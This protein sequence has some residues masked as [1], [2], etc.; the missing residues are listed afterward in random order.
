MSLRILE[1]AVMKLTHT[2]IFPIYMLL[3]LMSSL[4]TFPTASLADPP[5]PKPASPADN[6]M[7]IHLG[8]IK[9]KGER[10]VIKTLQIIK[11]ALKQPL[12]SD[13]KLANAV[14]CRLHDQVGSHLKQILICGTN[15]DLATRRRA[16][17]IATDGVVAQCGNKCGTQDYV[18]AWN[19][20]LT[21]QPGRILQTTITATVLKTLLAEVPLPAATTTVAPTAATRH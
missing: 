11:V 13:P 9:V 2:K 7:T 15:K 10:E 12:S 18:N 20:V 17:Q 21:T 6:A 3:L 4:L 19:E 1:D 5:T 16:F 14:V 8:N